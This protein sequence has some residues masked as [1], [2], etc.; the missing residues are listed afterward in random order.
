LPRFPAIQRDLSVI[1]AEPVRW[2]RLRGVIEGVDQ[3]LLA[4]LEY[5]TSYRGKPIP[6]GAKSVTVTLT[7]RSD[8]GTLR[9][10]QVDEQVQQVL[11]ALQQGLGATLRT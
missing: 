9:A 7:Y 8:T 2:S 11:A 6:D 4:G 1:V 10:Q 5:V 3:P